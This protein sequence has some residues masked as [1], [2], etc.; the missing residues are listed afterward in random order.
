MPIRP[1][2]RRLYPFDWPQLS[3]SVRF[4]RAGGRCERCD[5]PHGETV[6][7]LGDGV[8]WDEAGQHWRDGRGRRRR[9]VPP[10]VS[11]NSAPLFSTRVILA[12]AH[13]DHDPTNNVSNNLAALCQR[14]HMLHDA[15]EHRRQRWLNIF[16]RNALG[17]L[18][19]GRYPLSA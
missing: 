4:R 10:I 5:R 17:D 9:G 11:Q 13:L 19:L 3:H 8:W 2:Y 7:H 14:C 16:R 12:C 15:H 6:L 1:E 18:F